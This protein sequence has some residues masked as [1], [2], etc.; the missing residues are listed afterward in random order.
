MLNFNNNFS[1]IRL[2]AN[3]NIEFFDDNYNLMFEIVP[4][5]VKD[6]YL[7]EDLIWFINFLD[8][9]IE[10]LKKDING[11]EIKNHLDFIELVFTIINDTNQK[12]VRTQIYNSFK[13]I[14]PKTNFTNNKIH[15]GNIELDNKILQDIR[16]IILKMFNKNI[17]EFEEV[18]ENEDPKMAEFRAMKSKIAKMK[19]NKR[20]NSNSLG[21]KD[22]FA[23]I[24]YEFPQYKLEDLFELNIYNF[25]YLFEYIGKIANYEV[26]KIA[27]GN[28]IAKKHKYFIEN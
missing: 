25:Y 15:F 27:A 5:K 9:S 6:V 23:A 3:Q 24:L 10:D 2:I 1:E 18:E 22:M 19:E 4:V 12:T 8:T 26:S 11:F 20:K 13:K 16:K 14:I 28:G 7:D 21:F 17:E